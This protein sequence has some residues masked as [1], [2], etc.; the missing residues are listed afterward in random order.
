MKPPPI[1]TQGILNAQAFD[2]PLR[3][4]TA[5]LNKLL[6]AATR[7][8]SS[9][10]ESTHILILLADVPH[11]TALAGLARWSL[12]PDQWQSGLS[13]S[14]PPSPSS[15]PLVAL[16]QD[17]F[18]ESALRTMEEASNLA[19]KL[20]LPLI[21]DP[22]LLYCAL[23]HATPRVRELCLIA[24]VNLDKWMG[25]LER[26]WQPAVSVP[27]F[28]KDPPHRVL[29]DSF[30]Q[31]AREVLRL[32]RSEAE[33]LGADQAD[34]RHLL[35]AL[36]G[37]ETGAMH[38]GLYLQSIQPR[39]VHQAAM[40]SL[41]LR[42]SNTGS[43][44][45][46]DRGHL[47]PL[48]G[49]ILERAGEL[50]GRKELVKISEAMIVE[51]FLTIQSA[52]RRILEDQKVNLE[53]LRRTASTFE[54]PEREQHHAT[55]MADIQTIEK[56]LSERII[57]QGDAIQ[58]ILPHIQR[59]RFG[60]HNPN[61]PV[62]VF[63][64]CGQSG[65]GKTE[66]AKELARAVFGSEEN[67]VFLEMGQFNSP[68]S[69]NIFVGAPPGYVGYGEGKLTNGL[70]DKPQAVVLFDE[71][72]KA[73]A[74]V[75]DALLRFLDE[76]RISDPAGPVRDGTGCLVILT[77][78]VGS[79]Q[80]GALWHELQHNPNGASIMQQKL[81]EEFRKHQFRVE[82]LNRVDEIVLFHSLTRDDYSTIASLSI[83]KD[84]DRLRTEHNIEVDPDE[85]IA[86][87]IGAWCAEIG[88]GARA[89]HRLVQS[90]VITPVIDCCI[91][92]NSS[93]PLQLRVK[94]VRPGAG[95]PQGVVE[96][97]QNPPAPPAA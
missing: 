73:H 64:F 96:L 16:K 47:H 4:A 66:M 62:A 9:C 22:V 29:T 92:L 39:K 88:E 52:A 67:M 91:R 81:R 20:G 58:R 59:F 46:L 24:G 17:I 79:E 11:G 45:P 55:V 78:N 18:H 82:F 19:E 23:H 12:T 95:K 60:F 2:L 76:G 49:Q 30:G 70:R 69:M 56:R 32:L 34:A 6:M 27:V 40:L 61:R 41:R 84:L 37:P 97:C 89:V 7:T 15:D 25:D 14:V 94:A 74:R 75:L 72:E 57:G 31:D 1:F 8:Q 38:Y 43:T 5:D 50:A 80:L 48:L 28:A 53:E 54:P 33:A 63:L 21:T 83:Q 68:E 3:Q 51:A 35:L 77:S 13:S 93:Q 85:S 86:R 65:S 87:E 26:T 44:V 36:L 42:A 71:V 90:V 10:I